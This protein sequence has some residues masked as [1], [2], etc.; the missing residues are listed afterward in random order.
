MGDL[1]STFSDA[2]CPTPAA[3]E[4]WSGTPGG[5]DLGPG[6]NGLQQTP[7]QGAVCPVP[8]GSSPTCADLGGPP[9]KQTSIDGGT[10]EHTTQQGDI[11][12]PPL[13]TIDKR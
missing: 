8:D 2:V 3:S 7:W 13:R 6:A 4:G 1:K 9:V 5:F 12:M 10:Y 11:T